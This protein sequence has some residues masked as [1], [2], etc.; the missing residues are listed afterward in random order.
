MI[1][2]LP[3]TSQAVKWNYVLQCKA[4]DGHSLQ[5]AS[6]FLEATQYTQ[7][8]CKTYLWN[9][10]FDVFL[11]WHFLCCI[12]IFGILEHQWFIKQ[13]LAAI[14]QSLLF[15]WKLQ[16]CQGEE[17]L[18][19]RGY[20]LLW[21]RHTFPLRVTQRKDSCVISFD[22]VTASQD[23]IY[24]TFRSWSYFSLSLSPRLKEMS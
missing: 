10:W 7:A 13:A 20:A 17:N 19:T 23:L 6:S 18:P 12:M 24:P 4:R 21:R 16:K 8:I 5:N 9:A 2:S 14:P 15:R 1:V 3:P 22:F 11:L